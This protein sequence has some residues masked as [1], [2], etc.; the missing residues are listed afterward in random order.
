MT[1][2]LRLWHMTSFRPPKWPNSFHFP[3]RS[4][5][6]PKWCQKSKFGDCGQEL[7]ENYYSKVYNFKILNW[8]NLRNSR[9][10]EKSEFHL[11]QNL[12][13]VWNHSFQ[14]SSLSNIRY[15]FYLTFQSAS[16]IWNYFLNCFNKSCSPYDPRFN[17]KT[18]CQK[19]LYLLT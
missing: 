4:F 17:G 13:I 12:M 8:Y 7:E 18:P 16:D 5:W 1:T 6:V 3:I 10:A 2:F 15:Q 11:F 19:E 9:Y 14:I